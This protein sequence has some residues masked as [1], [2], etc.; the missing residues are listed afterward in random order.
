VSRLCQAGADVSQVN[1]KNKTALDLA[2]ELEHFDAF[3]VLFKYEQPGNY[4][5]PWNEFEAILNQVQWQN[6]ALFSYLIDKRLSEQKVPN[7]LF[8]LIKDEA[9]DCLECFKHNPSN[10]KAINKGKIFLKR[11]LFEQIQTKKELDKEV[12]EYSQNT[13][14]YSASCFSRFFGC[15]KNETLLSF[16]S[17]KRKYAFGV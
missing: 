13:G 14:V 9:L 1:H 2:L 4:K 11:I 3:V 17:N 16:I 7:N 5:T 8:K 6:E 10:V 15:P 12:M